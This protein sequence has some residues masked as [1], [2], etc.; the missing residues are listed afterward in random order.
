[1]AVRGTEERSNWR[2]IARAGARRRVGNE[3]ARG[4]LPRRIQ[5]LLKSPQLRFVEWRMRISETGFGFG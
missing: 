4:L 2:C 5:H 3:R 1:M